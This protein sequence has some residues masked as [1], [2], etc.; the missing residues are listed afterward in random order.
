MYDPRKNIKK[1]FFVDIPYRPTKY[2]EYRRAVIVKDESLNGRPFCKIDAV[3]HDIYSSAN[4][5]G[6]WLIRKFYDFALGLC[7]HIERGV[8]NIYSEA[9]FVSQKKAA[10][11]RPVFIRRAGSK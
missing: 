1:M 2:G 5:T 9:S 4:I 3:K 6:C 8:A 7:E 10:Y 11:Y